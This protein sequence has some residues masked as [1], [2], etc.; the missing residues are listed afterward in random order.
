MGRKKVDHSGTIINGIELLKRIDDYIAPNCPDSPI[1]RYECK[2]FCGRIFQATIDE[3]KRGRGCGC[4]K[5]ERLSHARP[6]KRKNITGKRFGRCVA[7][8][9]L[10]DGKWQCQCDCGNI[11]ATSLTHL[12]SGHTKSCGCFRSDNTR[13]MKRADL[14]GQKFTKLTPLRVA[15]VQKHPNGSTNAM[16]VCKC[17]CGN[18]TI[19]AAQEL[20]SGGIKSCG[21]LGSSFGEYEIERILKEKNIDFEREYTF[22][23]LSYQRPLR[24]DFAIFDKQQLLFVL[25]FQG[26]QHFSE[27]SKSTN[28]GQLQRDVTDNLKKDYC[29]K[30]NIKL[31]EITF[32][33]DIEEKLNCIFEELHVNT[34]PS[35][36]NT[37]KV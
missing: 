37:E 31:Y 18:Y 16:W 4:K 33:D 34:V 6:E 5:H 21:C 10:D 1:A 29:E 26:P 15:Y 13:Q 20:L 28:F 23:D 17:D 36:V 22:S 12:M 11:F 27:Y 35:S 9:R 25:E 19:V 8:R 2:C 32:Q 3:I 14:V 24:F 7:I 30:H